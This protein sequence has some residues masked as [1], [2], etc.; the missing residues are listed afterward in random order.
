MTGGP[1]GGGS[2]PAPGGLLR[3]LRRGR[4]AAAGV[5]LTALKYALDR[6]LAAAFGRSWGWLDYW[7]PGAFS[8]DGVPRAE[9]PF[10]AAL[11][12]LAA[13]FLAL[14]LWLTAR[15]LRDAGLSRWLLVLFF[16][17][18]VNVLLFVT[19]SLVPSRPPSAAA[20]ADPRTRSLAARVVPGSRTGSA[21]AGVTITTV[22]GIAAVALGANA[23]GVYGWG[24]FLG[25]PFALG[26]V[27]VLVYG[28]NEPRPMEDCIKVS[29][30]SVGLVGVGVLAVALEGAICLVM[31]LPLILPLAVLGSI[32]GHGIQSRAWAVPATAH[33]LCATILVLPALMGI[34]AGGAARPEIRDVSTT[35]VVDAPPREVWRHVVAFPALPAP[36]ELA[37]RAGIA[38]PVGAVIEGRGE[39][40]VRRC[41][42]STGDFV[43]P[44]TAWEA[45]HRLAFDVREQPP[46]MRELS[47]WGAVHP[48]HLDGFLRSRRGEFRLQ[49]L[50]GGRTSLTGTTWYEN[51]MWPAAYWRLWSDGLI[52]RIHGRVLRHV[53]AI[54]EAR[55]DARGV[56]HLRNVSRYSSNDQPSRRSLAARR[57]L[58]YRRS[59]V[60]RSTQKS[61]GFTPSGSTSMLRA[62]THGWAR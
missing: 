32:V 55:H 34:E 36:R 44:I 14:G 41:R 23:L 25:V 2:R 47:P 19:L 31:A 35:V 61:N 46:P 56:A 30:A 4:Y 33:T 13:P 10:Y 24:L 45:P 58:R 21:I 15:R 3:P 59:I 39:G 51:R 11:L 7:S 29:L 43:E 60:S 40:A 53:A 16:V 49:A 57:P 42:F 9:L 37:F 1:D 54:S 52:S 20:P 22:L 6:L 50:P 48:P 38:Y 62:L 18:V 28:A 26:L 8:I 12:A 27:S 5:V 17:P